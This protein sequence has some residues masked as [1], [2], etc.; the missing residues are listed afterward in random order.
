[1]VLGDK[2]SSLGKIPL[3]SLTLKKQQSSFSVFP[4]QLLPFGL[5]DRQKLKLHICTDQRLYNNWRTAYKQSKNSPDS[6]CFVWVMGT[7]IEIGTGEPEGQTAWNRNVYRDPSSSSKENW[8]LTVSWR[9]LDCGVTVTHLTF[10][11]HSHLNGKIAL[12]SS[13]G[14]W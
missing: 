11:G 13:E 3:G 14:L 9:P 12:E 8:T 7:E 2:D 5:F 1:M 10:A 6:F 4:F